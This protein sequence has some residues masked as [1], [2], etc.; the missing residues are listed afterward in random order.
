MKLFF[1]AIFIVSSCFT[2]A[3]A[4]TMSLFYAIGP[5]LETPGS[6]R[7]GLNEWEGGLLST[8]AVGFD[9]IFQV[10]N[11]TYMGFGPVITLTMG[12]SFG[13]YGS[14]G[15][16]GKLFWSVHYRVEL[17]SVVGFNGYTDGSGLLGLTLDF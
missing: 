2:E 17:Q 7:F 14:L 12:N 4:S 15:R 5:V 6:V 1:V 10:S 9:K 16:K 8:S 3:K 11:T 13:L